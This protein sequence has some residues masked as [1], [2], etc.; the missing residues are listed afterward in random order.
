MKE[1]SAPAAS[2]IIAAYNRATVLGYAIRSVLQ[3]DFADWELVVIGDGCT[4]DSDGVVRPFG[5]PRM[6]WEKPPVNPGGQSA[7][8]NRGLQMA[9]GRYVFFLSQDYLFF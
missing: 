3:Q 9:R 5:D 7:P 6:V 2:V 4:D 1:P 8:N